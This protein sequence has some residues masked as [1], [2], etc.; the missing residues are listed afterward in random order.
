MRDV[1]ELGA[2]SELQQRV[3]TLEARIEQVQ[4][5][6]Q[7]HWSS[8]RGYALLLA[9][10]GA[11]AAGV[12]LALQFAEW[13]RQTEGLGVLWGVVFLLLPLVGAIGLTLRAFEAWEPRV[14]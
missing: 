5:E 6:R 8:Q 12:G 2:V 13:I 1:G 14:W 3:L 9:S 7:R 4:A 11:T 10:V